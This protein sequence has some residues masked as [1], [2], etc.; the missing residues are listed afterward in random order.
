ML[1]WPELTGHPTELSSEKD[2]I[3]ALRLTALLSMSRSQRR[4]YF[5]AYARYFEDA[6]EKPYSIR[7]GSKAFFSADTLDLFEQLERYVLAQKRKV[8]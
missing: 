7:V 6:P 5:K 8:K 3:P 2:M 4:D 1:G